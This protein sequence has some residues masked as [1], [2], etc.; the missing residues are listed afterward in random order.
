MNFREKGKM[1]LKKVLNIESNILN[2]EK[3]IYKYAQND[4]INTIGTY[5]VVLYQTIGD[6]L[7]KKKLNKILENLKTKKFAWDHYIYNNS[8]KIIKE[9]DEFV[10]NPFDVK[11]GVFECKCGS[12]K[13]FTYSKQTRS[14]DEP[15][16]TFSYCIDCKKKWKYSG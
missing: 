8:F 11:E 12:K 1:C 16:T 10:I 2:L 6:I 13:V 5:N 4:S 14:C 7:Q 9:H 15:P 3:H